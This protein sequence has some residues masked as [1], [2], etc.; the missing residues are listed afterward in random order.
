MPKA[1]NFQPQYAAHCA[2]P[3]TTSSG[4]TNDT[5]LYALFGAVCG[6]TFHVVVLQE[7]KSRKTNICQMDYGTFATSGKKLP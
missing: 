6:I 5:D 1:E 2:L 3:I 7:T 4:V